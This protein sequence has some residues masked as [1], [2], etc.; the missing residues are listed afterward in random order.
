MIEVESHTGRQMV[1]NFQALVTA[2]GLGGYIGEPFHVE[3][4]RVFAWARLGIGC[5]VERL[6]WLERVFP[7]APAISADECLQRRLQA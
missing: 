1:A 2:R 7:G 4:D 6:Y 3:Q 5:A